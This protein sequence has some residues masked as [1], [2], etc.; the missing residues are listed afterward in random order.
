[1]NNTKLT[2]KQNNALL[3]AKAASDAWVEANAEACKAYIA[4]VRFDASTDGGFYGYV[5]A[6]DRLKAANI[7]FKKTSRAAKK[8]DKV[9]ESLG[10]EAE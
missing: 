4:Y 2:A 1:M 10:V 8:A 5:A 7:N 3:A 9:C 6:R